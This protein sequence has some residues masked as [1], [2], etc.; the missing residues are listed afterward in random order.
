MKAAAETQEFERMSKRDVRALADELST[1]A[2]DVV[3]KC[4][5]FICAETEGLWHGRGRAMMCRRLKHIEL[6]TAHRDRLVHMILDRLDSGHF[7]EQFRD[8]LR[9]AM[10][11]S[12]AKSFAAARRALNSPK[13]YVRRYARW[14]LSHEKD[15]NEA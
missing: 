6:P 5:R 10:H 9:L 13:D 2:A 7:S 3:E 11:L 4:V 12:S 15:A 14:V 8:Q 1:G